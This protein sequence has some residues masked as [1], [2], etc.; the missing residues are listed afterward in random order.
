MRYRFVTCDVF[1]TRRFYG[2]QLAVF[3]D[4]EGLDGAQMQ[5]LAREFN[6]SES[7]FVL[8]PRDPAHLAAVRIF[9]PR[10]ELGFAGHPTIGTALALAWQDRT[11]HDGDFTLE[12][13]AGRVPVQVRRGQ[14]GGLTAEFA[15]PQPPRHDPPLAPETV[16]AAVGLAVDDLVLDDGLPCVGSCGTP[17]LLVE[18][19][20]LDALGRAQARDF[21]GLPASTGGSI[22]LFTRQG[23]DEPGEL[24]ARMYAPGH[25]ILEDPATGSAV[26][27]LAG[28]LAG[29]P[30][31]ADGWHRWRIRQGVEM[32]RPSLIEAAA[33]RAAGAV[34]EVRIGGSAVP[35]AEGSI[36][37]DG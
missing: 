28:F 29:R 17:F 4:A 6:Y 3:P 22:F 25:G 36:E 35:V 1:T 19:A 18:L 34:A 7:T 24:R 23:T 31:L 13:K 10:G 11:P 33:H 14:G 30:G 8:P 21:A 37:V 5:A 12:L 15:A 9:T 2:N 16:A 26:A 20:G 27:A 32:G